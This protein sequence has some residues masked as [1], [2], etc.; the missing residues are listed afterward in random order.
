MTD[1]PILSYTS[2]REIPNLPYT[3]SVKKVPLWAEPPR[4]GYCLECPPPTGHFIRNNNIYSHSTTKRNNTHLP[5]SKQKNLYWDILKHVVRFP[6]ARS[7]RNIMDTISLS[8]F[9]S[10]LREY[11]FSASQWIY[12]WLMSIVIRY[13]VFFFFLLAFF[14]HV[15]SFFPFRICFCMYF[16]T[17]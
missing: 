4:I 10:L 5:E 6:F 15:Y 3:G 9:D 16:Y 17:F 1:S 11:D 13:K 12:C 7:P 2:T 8:T 14:W